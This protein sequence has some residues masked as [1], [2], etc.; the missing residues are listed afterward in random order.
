MLPLDFNLPTIVLLALIVAWAVWAVRRIA[1]RGLCDCGDHCGDGGSG[2]CSGCAGCASRGSASACAGC[3]VADKM[4][5][6]FG[7]TPD[8]RQ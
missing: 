8:G 7:G 4:V 3:S 1:G 6:D 2:G 5:A